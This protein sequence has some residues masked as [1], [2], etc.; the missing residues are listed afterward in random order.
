[1]K[2]RV[3]IVGGVAGGAS[4]AARIRRLDEE[5]DITVFE[6]GPHVSFSNCC[7]PYYLSRIV[8]ESERL[9]MMTPQAFITRYNIDVRTD[10]E[11]TAVDRSARKITVKGPDGTYEEAYDVLVLSPGAYPVMPK[12]IKGIDSE[13]VFGVRNVVDIVRLDEYL[14]SHDIKETAVIGGGFIG[15][16]IAE[17][18]IEAGF[19]VHLIEAADQI[20]APLDEDLVQILHKE[21]MDH[22][23]DLHLSCGL[24]EIRTDTIVLADGTELPA[25]AVVMAVGVRPQTELAVKAGLEIGRTGG[26]K[27]NGFYRTSDEHIYAVGDAVEVTNRLSGREMLLSLAGPAQM[28]A[29]AAADHI[30]GLTTRNRGF[31]GSSVIKVFN[32]YAAS[33]GLNEKTIQSL[34]LPYDTAYVIPSDKVSLMPGSRP[35]HLKVLF[36]V[37]SGRILGAQAVGGEQADRRIDVIAAVISMNGDLE[38]LRDLELCYAPVVGTAK[39]AVNVAAMVGLNVLNGF[40]KQVPMRCVRELVESGAYIIDVRE[41]GEYAAGHLKTAV[42][43]PLSQI[44]KRLD[45]IP[46]DRPVYVHCRTSQRSYNAV[47][48]LMQNGIDA[49]NIAGSYLAFSYYEYVKDV[50]QNR[51]SILTAY[52]FR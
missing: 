5:A 45:E 38:D 52:N 3:L 41:P 10:S 22:G 46:A 21:M 44:R 9:I 42:N 1:M 43:I 13:H 8:P 33:T 28:E 31:I 16:E 40:Y 51:E 36:E 37:P 25:G 11:V 27:V 24:A 39:D 17:N 35:I 47:R 32:T 14:R 7:L 12:S 34:G 2:K 23:I 50:L 6:K 4:V 30:C 26:I 48:F 29:R 49:I 15:C 18:L 20:M 19:K